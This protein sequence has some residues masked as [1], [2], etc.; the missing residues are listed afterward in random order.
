MMSST[1]S[2]DRVKGIKY[3]LLPEI[4]KTLNKIY[5]RMVLKIFYIW[6]QKAVSL[7]YRKQMRLAL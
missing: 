6:P 2:Q 4:T 3:T 7:R 5:E 1:S